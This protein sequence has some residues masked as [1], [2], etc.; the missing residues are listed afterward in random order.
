MVNPT[1]EEREFSPQ[2]AGVKL[3][4]QGK[5]WQISAPSVQATNEP[6]KKPEV[7][8]AQKEQQAFSNRMR[9]PPIS[10]NLYEFEMESA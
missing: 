8:I 4:G 9:V 7:E 10:V 3:R 6:G 2:I 5:L 1:E